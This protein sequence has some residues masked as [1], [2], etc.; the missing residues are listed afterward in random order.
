MGKEDKV[1]VVWVLLVC[2][3]WT[4]HYLVTIENKGGKT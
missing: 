3:I 1:V 4:F 2:K